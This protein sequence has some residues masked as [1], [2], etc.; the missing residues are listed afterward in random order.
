MDAAAIQLKEWD[1]L[2]CELQDALS[3]FGRE[4]AF[5]DGDYWIVDDNYSSPQHKV[6]VHQVSFITLPMVTAVQRLLRGR[7][8]RW[9]VLVVFDFHDPQRHPDDHGLT[10]TAHQVVEHLSQDRM[11]KTYGT[12]FHWGL[13]AI[14][15]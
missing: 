11:R 10:I 2:Y 5:G 9:E 3:K 13:R 14:D 8:L 1:A 6:C 7:Q 4:D 12:A 15:G